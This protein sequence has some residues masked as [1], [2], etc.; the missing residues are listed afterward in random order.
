MKLFKLGAFA[1][2]SALSFGASADPLT[3]GNGSDFNANGGLGLFTDTPGSSATFTNAV[4]YSLE[5]ASG[6]A[7]AGEYLTNFPGMASFA[8]YC[9]GI[10]VNL[11]NPND[12]MALPTTTLEGVARLFA[13]AGFNG[14]G[15]A[16]DGVSAVQTAALQVAIWEAVEDGIGAA[17]NLGSG[18]LAF[19]FI[20]GNVKAQAESYLSAAASNSLVYNPSVLQFISSAT[21]PEG[22]SQPLVTTVPEPS[23]YALMAACLGIVGLVARRKSA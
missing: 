10:D 16:N 6:A 3:V 22:V 5:G 9:L 23:T 19:S 8:S 1:L 20:D 14:Q 12:Y 7:F 21:S 11:Q 4:I 18:D 2:V 17:A 15:W 13:V